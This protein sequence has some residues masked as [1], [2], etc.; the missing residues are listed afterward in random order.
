MGD[1]DA[2][3]VISAAG[4]PVEAAEDR[5]QRRFTRTGGAHDGNEFAAF[6][7]EADALQCM[8]VNIA[9]AIHARHV[10]NSDSLFRHFRALDLG[11]HNR[12]C[13]IAVWPLVVLCSAVITRSPGC[14]LPL[15][16]SV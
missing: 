6:D 13:G 3:E 16:I 8:H 4:R 2:L 14:T 15:T 9:D 7:D 12:G 1:I 5:H 10:I 11:D